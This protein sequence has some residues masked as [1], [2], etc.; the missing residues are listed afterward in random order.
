VSPLFFKKRNLQKEESVVIK[1]ENRRKAF[2]IP[3]YRH[4]CN[5]MIPS[6]AI[7]STGTIKDISATGMKLIACEDLPD[8]DSMEVHL[9]FQL[10][11][12]PFQFIG[13]VARKEQTDHD[14]FEYGI[15]FVHSDE[16]TEEQLFSII[17][18]L[19]LQRATI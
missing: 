1:K 19:S 8:D 13:K 5:F 9:S 3:L 7:T 10:E 18:K 15:E 2:R 6:I 17:W 12:T 14:D 11:N 16:K 4:A